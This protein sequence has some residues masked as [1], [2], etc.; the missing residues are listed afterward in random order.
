MYYIFHTDSLLEELQELLDSALVGENLVSLLEPPPISA[1]SDWSTRS[2]LSFER[3]REARPFLIENMLKGEDV[4]SNSCQ[5]CGNKKAVVR[6]RDCLPYPFFCA[7]CDIDKHDF[8]PLHNRD[9]IVSGFLEPLPPTACFT[10]VNDQTTLKQL[11]KYKW[12]INSIFFNDSKKC[13]L[14]KVQ[15]YQYFP[16]FTNCS[17]IFHVFFSLVSTCANARLCLW[18]SSASMQRL[19]WKACHSHYHWW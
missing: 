12:Y 4:C 7:E 19:S 11:S 3:W 15:C 5:K 6:C 1:S 13:K 18:L 9:A 17:S 14:L 10:H 8:S 2:S 16:E